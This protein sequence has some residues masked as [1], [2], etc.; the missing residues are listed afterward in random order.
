M[1]QV[2][3]F[4]KDIIFKSKIAEITSISLEHTL[5]LDD[6]TISGDFI[7]SGDYKMTEASVNKEDF[8]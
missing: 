7:V 3:P 1:K 5:N 6:D 2:V 4:K 8:Y